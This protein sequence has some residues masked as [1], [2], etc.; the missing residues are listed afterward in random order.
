MV[1]GGY[2]HFGWGQDRH[3]QTDIYDALMYNTAA[4]GQWKKPPDFP[5]W[6]RPVQGRKKKGVERKSRSV[7]ELYAGMP[8]HAKQAM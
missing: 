5:D 8:T 1:R 2:E 7:K 4:T 6:P 3:I